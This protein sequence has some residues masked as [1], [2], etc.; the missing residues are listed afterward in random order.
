MGPMG[1]RRKT[2]GSIF[3]AL[4]DLPCRKSTHHA[5]NQGTTRW[6]EKAF[7]VGV[8]GCAAALQTE[9]AELDRLAVR[10]VFIRLR[11]RLTP[12]HTPHLSRVVPKHNIFHISRLRRGKDTKKV[13]GLWTS[14][15]HCCQRIT[16]GQR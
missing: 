9:F 7:T 3:L 6:Y 4:A 16:V 14:S 11:A 1:K 13:D 5:A 15:S 12:D 10:P 2:N 8:S